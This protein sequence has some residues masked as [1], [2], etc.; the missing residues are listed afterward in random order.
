V[1]AAGRVRQAMDR[2]EQAPVHR[3]RK[4][5]RGCRDGF[6]PRTVTPSRP[7]TPRTAAFRNH[8]GR[9][10]GVDTQIESW[11]TTVMVG[12]PGQPHPLYGDAVDVKQH[13]GILH[14][15]GEL[16]SLRDRQELIA[17]AHRYLARGIADADVR[18]LRVTR[19]AR[20]RPGGLTRWQRPSSAV[21]GRT[22]GGSDS[23]TC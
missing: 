13:G 16:G 21:A 9:T 7:V 4:Y 10:G 12:Q 17:E 1:V 2:L 19:H 18:R 6:H 11:W 5:L 15:S 22:R 20:R 14:L 3:S 23:P 8:M